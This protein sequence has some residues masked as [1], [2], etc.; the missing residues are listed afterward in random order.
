MP[1]TTGL[2][3]PIIDQLTVDEQDQSQGG[4]GIDWTQVI[5][6]G[7]TV[8]GTIFG[9]GQPIPTRYPTY[10]PQTTALTNM[11]PLLAIGAAVLLLAR[12]R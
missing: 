2:G 10:T 7:E 11:V 4:S 3:I 12:R 5:T 6:T 9:H 8:I 1:Y